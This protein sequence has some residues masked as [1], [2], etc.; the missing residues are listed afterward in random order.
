VRASKEVRHLENI[1]RPTSRG[2]AF[3]QTHGLN[4]KGVRVNPYGLTR[5]LVRSL[6]G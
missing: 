2:V 6:F 1:K 4:P 3:G 5:V